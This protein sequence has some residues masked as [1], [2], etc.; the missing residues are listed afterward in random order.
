[1]TVLSFY[2]PGADIW[3]RTKTFPTFFADIVRKESVS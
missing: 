2:K 1:M 3:E